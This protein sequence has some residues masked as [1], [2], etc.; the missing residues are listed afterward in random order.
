M[1]KMEKWEYIWKSVQRISLDSDL[2]AFGQQ[3]WEVCSVDWISMPTVLVLFKR[4][5]LNSPVTQPRPRKAWDN[6]ISE[7]ELPNTASQPPAESR[8]ERAARGE[9]VVGLQGDEFGDPWGDG[10]SPAN[11]AFMRKAIEESAD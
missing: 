3:G 8:F 6:G 5:L 7:E 2:N 1:E 9:L 4:K 10:N 11:R